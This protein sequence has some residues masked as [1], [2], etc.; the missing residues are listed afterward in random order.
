MEGELEPDLEESSD[1]VCEL[2]VRE[3]VVESAVVGATVMVISL[4]VVGA[5]VLDEEVVDAGLVDAEV[6]DDDVVGADVPRRVV[7]ASV[8]RSSATV[9]ALGGIRT[10]T[11]CPNE[12]LPISPRVAGTAAATV[13]AAITSVL[14]IRGVQCSTVGVYLLSPVQQVGRTSGPWY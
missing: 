3:V 13:S 6:V 8:P 4:G 1:E 5:V 11:L 7:F 10:G 2:R 12:A 14:F 9:I